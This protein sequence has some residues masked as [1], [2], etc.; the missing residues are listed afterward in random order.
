MAGLVIEVIGIV[1]LGPADGE[2]CGDCT[3]KTSGLK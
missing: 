1:G 2:H 3:G